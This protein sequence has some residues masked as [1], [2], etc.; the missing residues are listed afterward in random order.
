[1]LYIFCKSFQSPP[2]LTNTFKIKFSTQI[3][4]KH[5]LQTDYWPLIT[6]KWHIKYKV[7]DRKGENHGKD[8]SFCDVHWY[9]RAGTT[10][11]QSYT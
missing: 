1:M 3:S 4:S 8:Y 9:Y 2:G 5:L 11:M 7:D 10:R 6:K